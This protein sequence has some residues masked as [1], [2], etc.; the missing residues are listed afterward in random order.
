MKQLSISI[1]VALFL[2]FCVA[3]SHAQAKVQ[4]VGGRRIES[5]LIATNAW[6]AYQ[7]PS[8]VYMIA[9]YNSSAGDLYLH[10]FD[11]NGVPG[12]GALPT[13]APIRI[14]ASS[15]GAITDSAGLLFKQSV[16]IAVSATDR[17]LTNGSA[18]FLIHVNHNPSPY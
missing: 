11:T 18:V 13:L 10:V 4:V 17:S 6:R 1:F 12:N 5:S 9:A 3:E 16:Y 15:T 7:G 2:L 8:Q 14:P